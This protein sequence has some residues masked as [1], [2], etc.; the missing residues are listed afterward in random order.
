MYFVWTFICIWSGSVD[1][2]LRSASAKPKGFLLYT[3][4]T[5]ELSRPARAPGS[6]KDATPRAPWASM[7]PGRLRARV[8]ARYVYVHICMYLYMLCI[9]ICSRGVVLGSKR[10]VLGSGPGPPARRIRNE[11]NYN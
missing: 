9:C 10:V 5:G 7:D 4:A 11:P 8:K 3:K 6:L 2:L 1:S